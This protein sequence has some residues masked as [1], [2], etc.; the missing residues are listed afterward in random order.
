VKELEAAMVAPGF[1][2]DREKSKVASDRHQALMWEVG[3][4]IG[5]W[6]A[7]QDHAAGDSSES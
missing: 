7:L 1:Y 3:D 4:L 6:E 2:D 5:Q